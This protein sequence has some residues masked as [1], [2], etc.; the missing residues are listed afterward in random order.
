[1]I[2]GF[3]NKLHDTR[4]LDMNGNAS[5]GYLNQIILRPNTMY[6]QKLPFLNDEEY[7]VYVADLCGNNLEEIESFFSLDFLEFA[8]LKDFEAETVIIKIVNDINPNEVWFSRPLLITASFYS[9]DLIY[10]N[11]SD[12]YFQRIGVNAF[13]TRAIQESE[14]STYVQE[15]GNKVSGKATFTEMRK[16]IFEKL[17]NYAYRKINYILANTIVYLDSFRVTDKP[18]LSDADIDGTTNVFQS[19]LTASVNYNDTFEY[20]LQIASPLELIEYYPNDAYTLSSIENRITLVFNQNITDLGSGIVELRKDGSLYANLELTKIN[21][22][23]FEQ[24][25]NF[26]ENGNYTIEVPQG[27]YKTILFGENQP[28]SLPF[29]IMDGE[30][31]G[32]EYSNEFL[33]N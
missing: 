4:S 20:S 14:V 5:I 9:A 2:L 26:T 12:S 10:K 17:D 22:N 25:F 7:T 24:I 15:S 28:Y 11:I 31:E 6:C 30:Y 21:G 32:T 1:M 16:Y 18:L 23:T 29:T 8:S 33:I 27:K 13:F 3:Q 19:E